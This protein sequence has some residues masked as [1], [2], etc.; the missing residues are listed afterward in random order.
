MSKNSG[1]TSAAA[2]VV[3]GRW[4]TVFASFLIMSAA[5]ATYMFASYS[6]EI[7]STLGYDQQTLNTIS[8]FKDLGANVGIHAGIIAEF[9]PTWVVLAVGAAMNLFGYLMIYLALAGSI[10]RPRLWHMCLYICIGANSQSFANTGALVTSVKNFPQS[11]GIVLGLL[12]GFVGLSGAMFTQIYYA[13]YGGRGN[14]RALVLL[15][16]WLP[17]AVSLA[18]IGTIRV[19][20][21]TVSSPYSPARRRRRE[22]KVFCRFLYASAALALYLMVVIVVQK[23]VAFTHLEYGASA[24]A[25]LVLLFLPLAVVAKEEIS[26]YREKKK[27]KDAAPPPPPVSVSIVVE[28]SS[29]SSSSSSTAL[30]CTGV[31]SPPRRGEDYTIFQGLLSVDMLIIFV[32]TI[33]GLGGTLTATDNFGQ[34]GESLGYPPGSVATFVSL[35]SIWNYAGRVAAGFASEMLLSKYKLPRPLLVAAVLALSCA[36]YLLIAFGVPQSLYAASVVIG[37]CFGAQTPMFFAIISELFGLK[38]FSTLFNFGALASPIGS[39]VLNV[40]VVGRLYDREAV[41]QREANSAAATAAGGK[42][43]TCIG[44]ECFKMSFVIIAAVTLFGAAAMMV[45]VWRTRDFYRGDIYAKFRE[46]EKEEEEEERKEVAAEE[47]K[48]NHKVEAGELRPSDQG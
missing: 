24:A 33:C 41:R 48:E 39:Y 47:E 27:E 2:T 5:G 38:Y 3:T 17:A 26:L 22:F 13:I 14:S 37:F 30:S 19:V 8:F 46:E 6:K 23:K 43:L 7:K 21:T 20:K 45:L 16:G 1:P 15:I 9:V 12:K 18:F 32:A 28:E 40:Q 34:I 11:R 4:F 35:I 42:E 10:P 36:G 29:S 31:L 25:V 44:V